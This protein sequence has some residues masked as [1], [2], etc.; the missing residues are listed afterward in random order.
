MWT[1]RHV[2]QVDSKV[3]AFQGGLEQLNEA[4]CK[5]G[6]GQSTTTAEQW[7]GTAGGLDALSSRTSREQWG[8]P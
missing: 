5:V 8:R 7:N 6:S 4:C 1:R 2:L 3:Q